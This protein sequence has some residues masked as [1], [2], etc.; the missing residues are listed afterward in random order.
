MQ[1]EMTE[2]AKRYIEQHGGNIQIDA[3][4]WN[5]C[6]ASNLI[7]R[8]TLGCLEGDNYYLITLDKIQVYIDKGIENQ[9]GIKVRLDEVWNRKRLGVDWA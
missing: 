4:R 5:T 8:V 7:P 3:A 2:Q 9:R 6:C 1:V